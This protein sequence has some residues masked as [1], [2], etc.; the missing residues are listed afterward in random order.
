MQFK[1][2]ATSIMAFSDQDLVLALPYFKVRTFTA[3]DET[4]IW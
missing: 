4:N 3:K 1:Q 2:F